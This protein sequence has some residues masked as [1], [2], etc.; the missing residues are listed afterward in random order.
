VLIDIGN[1]VRENSFKSA[2][3]RETKDRINRLIQRFTES[4]LPT[5]LV[6]LGSQKKDGTYPILKNRVYKNRFALSFGVGNNITFE[7]ECSK[8]Q[9]QVSSFD[10]TV[11]PVIPKRHMNRIDYMPV[12]I[13]GNKPARN[14]MTI[15]EILSICGL[16][17]EDIEIVKMDIEGS[18]W[19]ILDDGWQVFSQVPQ[20][21]V[22]FHNLDRIVDDNHSRL[23]ESVIRRILRTHQVVYL[24]PNNF[25]GHVTINDKVWPFTIEALFVRKDLKSGIDLGEVPLEEHILNHVTNWKFGKNLHLLSW[26]HEK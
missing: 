5:E 23:Y 26:F 21:I 20:F 6:F 25:S 14:C 22:E 15:R 17:M 11:A 1:L 8:L 7:I 2:S 18:E 3:N 9:M 12:G 10:H 19:D 13:C 16:K 24:S 4:F